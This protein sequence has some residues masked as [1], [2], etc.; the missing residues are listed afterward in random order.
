[1]EDLKPWWTSKA[2]WTGV[3]GSLWGV[4]GAIGIL[5]EG[6]TQANVLT[7]VLALMGIGSVVSR[8]TAKARIG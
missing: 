1:M 4:A 5:P 7:V 6:L 3:I 2:I 8:K